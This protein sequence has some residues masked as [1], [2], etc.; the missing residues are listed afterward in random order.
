MPCLALL[1]SC[2]VSSKYVKA[3]RLTYRAIAHE[4]REYVRYDLKLDAR[5]KRNRLDTVMSWD[6]RITAA[7]LGHK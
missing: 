1:A 7:E 5:E 3:D 2:S 6:I 4:Y